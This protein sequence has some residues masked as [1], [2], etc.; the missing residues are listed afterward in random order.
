MY[1]RVHRRYEKRTIALADV[2]EVATVEP[3]F[4]RGVHVSVRVVD[5]WLVACVRACMHAAVVAVF[6]ARS[7]L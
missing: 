6:A 2:R 4:R 5:A 7:R 1:I 3:H